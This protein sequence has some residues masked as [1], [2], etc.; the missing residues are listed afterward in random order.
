MALFQEYTSNS[1]KQN[2]PRIILIIMKIYNIQ[3]IEFQIR[4]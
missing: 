2:E 1:L 4:S 3:K